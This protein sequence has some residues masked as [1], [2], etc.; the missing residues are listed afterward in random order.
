MEQ[1]AW[2]RAEISNGAMSTALSK[3]VE[4]R[5]FSGG[6]R[7]GREAAVRRDRF[8]ER[9]TTRGFGHNALKE[10]SLGLAIFRFSKRNS[11]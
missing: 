7:G 11:P 6:G 2:P 5:L 3:A 10:I 1:C 4:S 8:V 9:G